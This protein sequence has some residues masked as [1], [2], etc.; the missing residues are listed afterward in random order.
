MT[1]EVSSVD[2]LNKGPGPLSQFPVVELPAKGL[3][4]P[5]RQFVL[6][7]SCTTQIH[8]VSTFFVCRFLHGP[9]CRS[10]GGCL[11][12]DIVLRGRCVS[13]CRV[14]FLLAMAFTDVAVS[15]AASP[16]RRVPAT[17]PS[18]ITG[19]RP[20]PSSASKLSRSNTSATTTV[21][22][23]EKEK[24]IVRSRE[25]DGKHADESPQK[26]SSTGTGIG[27]SS[28]GN[29]RAT[30]LP[31][32][33][34]SAT[35]N[36]AIDPLSQVSVHS[37]VLNWNR[38]GYCLAHG[39]RDDEGLTQPNAMQHI[40]LRTNEAIPQRLR[41]TAKPDSQSHVAEGLARLSAEL[42]PTRNLAPTGDASRDKKYV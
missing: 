13:R 41:Q 17:P 30:T 42:L 18:T 3:I 12:K 8:P 33:S 10:L 32:T 1:A 7:D 29:T 20:T 11:R 40:F 21:L 23:R 15:G 26:D 27:P 22:H 14:F 16:P 39:R 28:S 34:P 31:P 9:T 36:P 35:S 6:S 24:E 19:I 37:F 5:N 25:S 2:F 4:S 38:R